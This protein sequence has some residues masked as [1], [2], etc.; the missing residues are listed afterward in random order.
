VEIAL[1][2]RHE[3]LE[4]GPRALANFSERFDKVFL[5]A[6]IKYLLVPVRDRGTGLAIGAQDLT[7]T[8]RN[9]ENSSFRRGRRVFLVGTYRWATLGASY[10][11]S[12]LGAFAAAQLDIT[13]NLDLLAEWSSRPAFAH[14]TP[15]PDNPINSNLGLRVHPRQLPRLRVDLTAIGDGE[16]DF[17]FSFS[18]NLSP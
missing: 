5:L 2:D 15:G 16:F 10:D 18:Y 17:G 11:D 12:K 7:G 9:F 4:A 1:T 3:I 8:T 14:F 13:D 6:N